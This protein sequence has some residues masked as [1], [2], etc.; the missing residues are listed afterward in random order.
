MSP[1]QRFTGGTHPLRHI[2]QPDKIDPF[3]YTRTE[4]VVRK[5]GTVTLDKTL[6]EAPLSLR[7]LQIELRY[8]PLLLDRVEVW[9][10]GSF[11]GLATKVD[12]HLNSQTYN[13]SHNYERPANS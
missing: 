13:R 1:H 9:H 5:D 10:K 4:R 3:F 12:L 6:H 11:H 2:E 7:A 8:D